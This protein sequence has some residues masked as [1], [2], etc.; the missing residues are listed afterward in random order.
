MLRRVLQYWRQH[1][2]YRAEL[3]L[4]DLQVAARQRRCALLALFA[5]WRAAA[6]ALKPRRLRAERAFGWAEARTLRRCLIG[7]QRLAFLK[8]MERCALLRFSSHRV[9]CTYG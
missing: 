9:V 8:F 6:R 4:R 3:R 1:A 5:A 7:W 2:R